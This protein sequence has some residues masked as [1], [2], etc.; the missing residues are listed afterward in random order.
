MYYLVQT[1][2]RIK[3]LT[4]RSLYYFLQSFLKDGFN[5]LALLRYVYKT[6]PGS[7][8]LNFSDKE[9]TYQQL[10][11][12]C[13]H[14]AYVLQKEFALQKKNNVA[15]LCKN[16]QTCVQSIIALSALGVDIYLL[17]AEM[18]SAQLAKIVQQH[19]FDLVI[20]DAE[21]E[22]DVQQPIITRKVSVPALMQLTEKHSIE[23]E[24]AVS[25]KIKT[26]KAGKVIVLTGGSSGN[27]KTA[28]RNA[29]I[30]NFSHPLAELLTKLKIHVYR[31]VYIA[32]PIYHG[33]GFSALVTSLVLGKK[34]FLRE[35]ISTSEA[36]ALIQKYEIEVLILVPVILQRLLYVDAVVFK[37][38]Q[39]I[40]SGGAPIDRLLVMKTMSTADNKL[41]NLYGSSEAGFSVLA[42][43]ADL[44]QHPDSIGKPIHGVEVKII[45]NGQEVSDYETGMIFIRCNWTADNHAQ[46]WVGTGDLGFKN[47][48]GYIFLKGRKDNMIVSGGENVYP[49]EVESVL[50]QH[51]QILQAFVIG[52]PD[53]LYGQRLKVFAVKKDHADLSEDAFM[54]WLRNKVARYQ[55]PVQIVFVET[56]PMLETGKVNTQELFK[57]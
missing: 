35:K 53:E 50:Y 44:Q 36:A 14:V 21:K 40:L 4:F 28:A 18:S 47:E 2:I 27:Y 20:Y 7:V 29:S 32:T 33:Y 11:D 55:M 43:P 25:K 34:I 22:N 13:Y 39:C 10:Y 38:V 52:V 51:E 9:L 19:T 30:L 1:L 48:Q 37:Q 15:V 57:Y 42:T 56:I 12:E 8:A 5:L 45:N 41:F 24:Y 23:N 3:L 26:V 16:H 31:S 17:N 6:Y 54:D 49:E 46:Q